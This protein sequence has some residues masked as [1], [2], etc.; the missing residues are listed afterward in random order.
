M[1]HAREQS[2]KLGSHLPPFL[3]LLFL[4]SS[5]SS[6]SS[7]SLTQSR[8]QSIHADGWTNGQ[9]N[10]RYSQQVWQQG[11]DEPKRVSGTTVVFV[12]LCH[13]RDTKQSQADC[14]AWNKKKKKTGDLLCAWF[15]SMLEFVWPW[16][17]NEH[18]VASY[19][20]QRHDTVLRIFEKQTDSLLGASPDSFAD[21]L[22]GGLRSRD[23]A[24]REPR[25]ESE[26][27][28]VSGV[29]ESTFRDGRS[30]ALARENESERARAFPRFLVAR[31]MVNHGHGRIV[32]RGNSD[33]WWFFAR[34]SHERRVWFR[35]RWNF[36]RLGARH[37]LGTQFHPQWN[38]IARG[39]LNIIISQLRSPRLCFPLRKTPSST[40]VGGR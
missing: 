1:Q 39:K 34:I 11:L 20:V 9:T 38:Y 3:S 18:S 2:S 17:T 30:C 28:D 22:A 35:R 25:K 23:V 19:H 37:G 16:R 15:R 40:V 31:W 24:P 6:F 27:N 36:I 33:L 7:L 10:A 14:R 21:S 5:L 26:S 12:G 32:E 4:F 8:K 29:G 13:F